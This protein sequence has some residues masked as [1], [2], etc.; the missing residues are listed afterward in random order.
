MYPVTTL[1]SGGFTMAK[2]I[3]KFPVT[4]ISITIQGSK[5]ETDVLESM[6]A[7]RVCEDFN[8]LGIPFKV[9]LLKVAELLNK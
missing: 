6:V 1:N 2:K 7:L 9:A 3:K 5:K 8:K 4:V